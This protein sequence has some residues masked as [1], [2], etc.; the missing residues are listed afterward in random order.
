MCVSVCVNNLPQRSPRSNETATRAASQCFYND[1]TWATQ[2]TLKLNV[3][4]ILDKNSSVDWGLCD[5]KSLRHGL[6]NL[7]RTLVNPSSSC[8]GGSGMNVVGRSVGRWSDAPSRVLI[9]SAYD[10]VDDDSGE[11]ITSSP[12]LWLLLLLLLLALTMITADCFVVRCF[13]PRLSL[14][15]SLSLSFGRA[16]NDIVSY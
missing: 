10:D 15:L 4:N 11:N 7:A 16:H 8:G 3:P 6:A 9:E 13:R 2:N 14:S 12:Q 5:P 1:T